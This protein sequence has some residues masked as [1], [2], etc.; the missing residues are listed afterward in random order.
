MIFSKGL[1]GFNKIV[2][3]AANNNCNMVTKKVARDPIPWRINEINEKKK[4]VGTWKH[5]YD[6][7]QKPVFKKL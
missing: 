3:T 4:S 7:H 5:Q 6:N 2:Q 1:S